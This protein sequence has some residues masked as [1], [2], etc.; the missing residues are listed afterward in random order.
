MADSL[1]CTSKGIRPGSRSAYCQL[2]YIYT[3][4]HYMFRVN[5]PP[6]GMVPPDPGPRHNVPPLG[7][8][9]LSQIPCKYHANQLAKSTTPS[10]SIHTNPHAP[11]VQRGG[12]VQTM[13]QGGRGRRSDA[14]AY[15]YIWASLKGLKGLTGIHSGAATEPIGLQAPLLH[16]HE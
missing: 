10:T 15:I 11:Q 14:G 8:A 13:N 3:Y 9:R 2:L 4:I 16:L 6:H 12:G 5:L 1:P 7:Y